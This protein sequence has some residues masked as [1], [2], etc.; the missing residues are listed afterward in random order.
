[1]VLVSHRLARAPHQRLQ[2]RQHTPHAVALQDTVPRRQH[3]PSSRL[4]RGSSCCCAAA[5]RALLLL[6]LLV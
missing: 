2:Q 6:V 1:V 5:A 3:R 4:Q